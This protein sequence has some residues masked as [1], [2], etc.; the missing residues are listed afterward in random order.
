MKLSFHEW[1]EWV[2]SMI[3]TNQDNDV[4]NRIG[5]VYAETEIELSWL[6]RLGVDGYKKKKRWANYVTD[7]IDTV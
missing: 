2:W 3:K 6:I 1:S 5:L 7:G 4:T